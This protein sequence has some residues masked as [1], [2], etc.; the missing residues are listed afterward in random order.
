M[1]GNNESD[2]CESTRLL[3]E[4]ASKVAGK[5]AEEKVD[6]K[7][8]S[9]NY[10]IVATTIGMIAIICLIFFTIS[11]YSYHK[12]Q[13]PLVKSGL[14]IQLQAASGYYLRTATEDVL[15]AT[16]EIPWIGGSTFTI[17]IRPNGCWQLK[18]M[19]TG[20]WVSYS[21]ESMLYFSA[22]EP[23]KEL[24][25]CFEVFRQPDSESH[26]SLRVADDNMWLTF[27]EL[28]DST[29]ALSVTG[30]KEQR[31]LFTAHI[32]DG[33]VGVNLGG[34]FVPGGLQTRPSC[35]HIIQ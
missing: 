16:E 29:D 3:G 6:S 13:S 24:A 23:S 8:G 28:P 32:V 9:R 2:P 17:D 22:A 35:F 25:I 20:K 33:I 19:K 18:S 11:K 30:D 14:R 4:S 31:V 21:G 1:S 15:V 27:V 5:E 34:W 12:L 26:L 7:N 10:V